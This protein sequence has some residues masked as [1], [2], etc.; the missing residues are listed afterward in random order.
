MGREKKDYRANIASIREMFPDVGML[1]VPQVATWMSV[2]RRTVTAMIE[3]RRDPLV[4]VDV[5]NGKKNKVYRV[6]I[7]ALA[8]FVS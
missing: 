5:G 6:S 7:E 1:T 2:D 3:R 4:A 8:R